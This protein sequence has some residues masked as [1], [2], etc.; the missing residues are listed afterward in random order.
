MLKFYFFIVL[1]LVLYSKAITQ[2][3]FIRVDN[4]F[5]NHGDQPYNV[6]LRVGE[7]ETDYPIYNDAPFILTTTW[8]KN[9][10]FE[11]TLTYCTLEE[12]IAIL[13]SLLHVENQLFPEL[14]VDISK[15]STLSLSEF[16]QTYRMYPVGSVFITVF[17]KTEKVFCKYLIK[18]ETYVQVLS[19]KLSEFFKE[20]E[21]R[22][23][24]AFINEIRD[25]W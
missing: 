15:D 11:F 21:Q 5:F 25:M 2:T 4:A 22:S 12:N 1:T 16:W 6:D 17:N 20:K 23:V 8:E 13:D 24:S 18:G 3:S 10:D 9:I 14:L 19:N 7:P